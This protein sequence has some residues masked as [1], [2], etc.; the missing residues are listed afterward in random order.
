MEAVDVLIVGGGLVGCASAWHL[1]LGGAS[2]LL[3]E[4]GE[5]NSGASSQN[6]GSLHFQMERRFLEDSPALAEIAARTMALNTLAIVEWRGLEAALGVPLDI[7]MDG[8]LMVAE[9]ADDLRL[10]EAKVAREAYWNLPTRLVDGPEARRIAPYLSERVIGASVLDS[11]GHADP[12]S[13]TRAFAAAAMAA[14]ATVIADCRLTA[15]TRYPGR[16]QA[17]LDVGGERR[18]VR[19]DTLL[20]AAGA[21]TAAVGAVANLHL[22]I[23]PVGLT[24]NVTERIAPTIPHLIQHVGRRLSLKQAHAGNVL[25]GGGWPSRL[26]QT[27]S[28]GFDLSRPPLTVEASIAGNLAAARA[29]VPLVD[30][31]NLI[32]TWTGIAALTPDHLPLVG[33]V[34]PATRLFVAAGGSGFTLGPTFARLISAQILGR[35]SGEAAERLAVFSPARFAHLNGFMA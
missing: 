31:L 13:I 29:V 35:D 11:E 14:G 32:R 10:L 28:G 25:I 9:T 18:Q 3:V 5:I 17:E 22:P 23:Y 1:A 16:Y 2:V 34:S 27:P 8:G 4:Q 6:A 15:L 12:R 30:D 21:W 20:L 7:A 26:R 19:A 33:P 24:M